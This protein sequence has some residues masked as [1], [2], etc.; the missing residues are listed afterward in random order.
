MFG[1]AILSR[2]LACPERLSSVQETVMAKV[3]NLKSVEESL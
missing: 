1:S 3:E 2:I